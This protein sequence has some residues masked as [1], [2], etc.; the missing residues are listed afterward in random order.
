MREGLFTQKKTEQRGAEQRQRKQSNTKPQRATHRQRHT[1]QTE[2]HR[3]KA[4]HKSLKLRK[5]CTYISQQVNHSSHQLCSGSVTQLREDDLVFNTRMAL[6]KSKEPFSNPSPTS[7]SFSTLISI[8]IGLDLVPFSLRPSY[9]SRLSF[10]TYNSPLIPFQPPRT[11]L[12][13]VDHQQRMVPII[14]TPK[15]LM[16]MRKKTMLTLLCWP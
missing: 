3:E 1:T 15:R 12:A 4:Q 9:F 16:R 13:S 5:A 2:T 8:K 7:L 6:F 10:Q 14:M 11:I